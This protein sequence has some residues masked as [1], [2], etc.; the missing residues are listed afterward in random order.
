MVERVTRHEV[1]ALVGPTDDRTVTEILRLEPSRA[2][3][4]E[5]QAWVENDEAMLNDGRSN[6]SGRIAR[7]IEILKL[8][9]EE[10]PAVPKL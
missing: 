6:P 1:E 2:E 4:A 9:D 7:L 3:I 8:R 5:A 10:S